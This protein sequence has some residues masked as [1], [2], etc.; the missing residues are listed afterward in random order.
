MVHQIRLRQKEW[1]ELYLKEYAKERERF[2]FPLGT[3]DDP[4]QRAVLER[5][6]PRPMTPDEWSINQNLQIAFL[7]LQVILG[8]KAMAETG[9]VGTTRVA[10]EPAVAETVQQTVKRPWSTPQVKSVQITDPFAG[11]RV[12]DT[13]VYGPFYRVGDSLGEMQA[14]GELWGRGQ[15]QLGGGGDRSSMPVVSA[16]AYTHAMGDRPALKFFTDARPGYSP[17][18]AT[19]S[20]TR[21]ASYALEPR[22]GIVPGTRLYKGIESDVAIIKLYLQRLTGH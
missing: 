3:T 9:P 2:H 12:G 14:S 10:P 18:M 8:V 5:I 16:N 4:A 11:V 20:L 7:T 1:D 17:N 6:G 21:N 22:P 15:N 13:T 19:W